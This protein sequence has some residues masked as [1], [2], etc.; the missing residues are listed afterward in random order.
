MR[1]LLL[2]SVVAGLAMWVVG[3]IFW[4]P[5]LG[6]I[7]YSIA[8][9]ADTA[10][11]H[12][13]LKTTLAH[14]GTGAYLIPS[15]ATNIGTQLHAQGPVSLVLF[16]NAGF[17]GFDTAALLWGLL[18][19]VVTALVL[20]IGLRG[21]AAHMSFA[22]RLRLVACFAVAVAGYGDL[23][24]PVFN[25]APWGY[26]VYGFVADVATWLAAGAVFARWFMPEPD[27]D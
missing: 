21:A 8:S 16:T 13:A 18:L 22:G 10:T 19:A 4:G 23:G 5:L 1:Q 7:P 2:G 20:G 9:D 12:E 3:F 6:W 17:P 26:F 15:T 24:Q 25:H 27:F 14:S 11:L